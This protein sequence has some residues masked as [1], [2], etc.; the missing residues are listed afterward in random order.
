MNHK[1]EAHLHDETLQWEK[2]PGESTEIN[3]VNKFIDFLTRAPLTPC[4]LRGEAGTEK[5]ETALMI[6]EKS[7]DTDGE[8]RVVNCL[9]HAVDELEG[10]IF[11]KS[12]GGSSELGELYAARN[13]TLVI[14]NVERL[15]ENAQYRLHAFLDSHQ[16]A[17]GGD[18]R[19]VELRVRVIF[20][21]CYDIDNFVEHG[22]FSRELYF[23]LKAF[24][25]S[26][27]P[28]RQR[29]SDLLLLIKYF[30]DHYSAMYGK[31]IDKI[32]PELEQELL[33]YDWPGNMEELRLVI[34]RMVLLNRDNTLKS[35]I[36]QSRE[37]REDNRDYETDFLGNCSLKDIERLHIERAL[38]RTRGN[39][40]RAAEILSISRTTLREK[41]K[42]FNLDVSRN[43]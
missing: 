27:P 38:V 6:H 5:M 43:K 18:S 22:G 3:Q 7:D 39:K 42:L 37:Q 10:L 15:P 12:D 31:Q 19:E 36:L 16:L 33:Q 28:L 11:G 35:R 2:L 40:S 29:R 25:L 21:T 1:V 13:G 23:R 24:E 14:E 26:L 30:V 4:L 41:M 8:I 20:S 34:Q 17:L 9:H 32:A